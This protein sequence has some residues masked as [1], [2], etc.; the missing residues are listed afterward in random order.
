M[1]EIVMIMP[2]KIRSKKKKKKIE[3]KEKKNHFNKK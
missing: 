2:P 1:V 3:L